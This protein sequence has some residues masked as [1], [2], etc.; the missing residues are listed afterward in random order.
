[1]RES[2]IPKPIIYK[3]SPPASENAETVTISAQD[4]FDSFTSTKRTETRTTMLA[5]TPGASTSQN[6]A[7]MPVPSSSQTA[8][9]KD[10]KKLGKAK[11]TDIEMDTNI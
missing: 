5:E 10:R 1:L 7:N 4:E 8:D 9:K 6:D 11:A 3:S 2:W